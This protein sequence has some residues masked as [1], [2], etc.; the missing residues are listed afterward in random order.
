MRYCFICHTEFPEGTRMEMAQGGS[1]I[2]VPCAGTSTGK[3][4]M[5]RRDPM[6]GYR[7]R[8]TAR[9][10]FQDAVEYWKRGGTRTR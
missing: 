6:Q 10:R 2:C 7:R 9:T 3:L 8:E 4:A 1:N 5:Q